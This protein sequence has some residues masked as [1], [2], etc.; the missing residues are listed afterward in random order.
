[1]NT[2][3][4][5]G[6][7]N[8]LLTV[9]SALDQGEKRR[10]EVSSGKTVSQAIK[11]EGIAPSGNFDVFDAT[12]QVVSDQPVTQVAEET[13]YVG[14]K[15]VAGGALGVPLDRLNELQHDFP[16]LLPISNFNI[17]NLGKMLIVTIP[18]RN[19]RTRSKLFRCILHFEGD[20]NTPPTPYVLDWDT[21][22]VN[23][24]GNVHPGGRR[25]HGY[26]N[27]KATIPGTNKQGFWVCYGDFGQIYSRLDDDPI[28]RIN[29]F[30]NHLVHLLN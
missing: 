20:S 4:R 2:K 1:M 7:K 26:D 18:D 29:A 23:G 12:G 28:T 27:S 16:T 13:V 14:P 25:L 9:S 17:G 22:C 19:G 10:I 21:E 24:N 5:S 6:Q 30:L 3:N 11:D 15:S 8:V